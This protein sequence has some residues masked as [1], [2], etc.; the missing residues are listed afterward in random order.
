MLLTV[1]APLLV[2][3]VGILTF[4]LASNPKVV[5]VGECLMF[6]G[7]FWATWAIAEQRWHL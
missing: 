7:L 4:A 6:V 1:L 5:R 3:V 2:A